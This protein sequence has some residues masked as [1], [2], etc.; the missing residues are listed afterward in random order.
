LYDD[1]YNICTL[2]VICKRD[3]QDAGVPEDN[4]SDPDVDD[5]RHTEYDN[6]G[7]MSDVS[8]IYAILSGFV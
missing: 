4:G 2:L 7:Q 5:D 1:N 8:T 6:V 3:H